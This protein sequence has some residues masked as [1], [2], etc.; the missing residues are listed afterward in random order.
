MP[1]ETDNEDRGN[2]VPPPRLNPVKNPI[3]GRNM[4][5]WA[6]VYFT[7]PPEHREQAVLEL[8]HEL[9]AGDS[10]HPDAYDFPASS[11]E[12]AFATSAFSTAGIAEVP[13]QLVGCQS[14]GREN[15]AHQNFCSMCGARLGEEA[16][17]NL[18]I[19]HFQAQS[20]VKNGETRLFPSED[21][22][23]E[24]GFAH[25]DSAPPSKSY[26]L[27]AGAVLAILVI[28]LVYSGWRSMQATSE[29]PPL[30]APAPP[31]VIAQPAPSAP[32][33]STFAE[34]KTVLP[35]RDVAEIV[36][37]KPAKASA[38]PGSLELAMA[39]SFLQGTEG[40]ERNSDEAVKWLW[41]AVGKRNA[42][43]ML[44]LSD[45][46]LKGD[47]IPKN[48]DQAR[49]LLRVAASKGIKGA[50]ERLSHLQSFGCE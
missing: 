19:D 17:L 46:Y 8:L 50:A 30:P 20:A 42:D 47:G 28:A 2:G 34:P 31:A 9:E 13:R 10:S 23:D 45:L 43:A 7:N 24:S 12:Q 22:G 25:R 36:V 1:R 18:R 49:I 48:C 37:N 27:Y 33:Q 3:L 15:P 32:A 41:E 40:S 5:R 26:R 21:F 14:C 29:R 39:E 44:R 35:S 11:P 6:E 16:D 38:A 4:G